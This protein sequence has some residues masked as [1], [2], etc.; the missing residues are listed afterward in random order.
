[1]LLNICYFKPHQLLTL[2]IRAEAIGKLTSFH[3]LTLQTS[4]SRSSVFHCL[5]YPHL[6][7]RTQLFGLIPIQAPIKSKRPMNSSIRVAYRTTPS[8]IDITLFG[9]SYGSSNSHRKSSLSH[10]KSFTMQSQSKL[11]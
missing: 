1:M 4:P 5:N 2:L 9:R 11:N 6:K 8:L 7:Q 10:G 3:K